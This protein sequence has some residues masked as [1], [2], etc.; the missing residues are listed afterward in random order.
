[1]V[2]HT[3]YI[4]LDVQRHVLEATV[5]VALPPLLLQQLCQTFLFPYSLFSLK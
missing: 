5:V 3:Q 4:R 2:Q 1:M